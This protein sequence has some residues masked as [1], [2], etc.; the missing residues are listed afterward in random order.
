MLTTA[1]CPVSLMLGLSRSS[2]QRSEQV[3]LELSSASNDWA[4]VDVAHDPLINWQHRTRTLDRELRNI[5]ETN[6]PT[7]SQ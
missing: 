5:N 7:K 6:D 2:E 4:W 3:S 1:F